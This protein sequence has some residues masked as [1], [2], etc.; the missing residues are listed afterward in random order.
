MA[1]R[2][3]GEGSIRKRGNYW[4][5]RIMDGYKPNGRPRVRTFTAYTQREVREKLKAF[6]QEKAAGLKAV[7]YGFSSWA[8]IWFEGHRGNVTPTTQEGYT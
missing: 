5:C 2:R 3:N 4:E 1:K 8:A 6:Q 7:N